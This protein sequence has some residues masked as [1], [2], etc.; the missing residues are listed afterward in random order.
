MPAEFLRLS[1]E[2]LSPELKIDRQVRVST[3]CGLPPETVEGFSETPTK[4]GTILVVAVTREGVSIQ[5]QGINE[6]FLPDY[7]CHDNNDIFG[8]EIH[9][10]WLFLPYTD[11]TTEP[12][13]KGTTGFLNWVFPKIEFSPKMD[14][15]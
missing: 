2:F 14:G 1:Y 15:L 5:H 8:K 4:S 9:C 11:G 12:P 3:G 7:L 10:S 13:R 6:F